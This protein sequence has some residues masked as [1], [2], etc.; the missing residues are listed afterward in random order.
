MAQIPPESEV[1]NNNDSNFSVDDNPEKEDEGPPPLPQGKFW[2]HDKR[3][4]SIIEEVKPRIDRG[5]AV[6]GHEKYFEMLDGENNK[7]TSFFFC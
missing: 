6:W 7:G 4:G 5:P 3:D 1:D 2:Q